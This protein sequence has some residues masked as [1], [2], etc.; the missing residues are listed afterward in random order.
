[1]QLRRFQANSTAMA[2][3]AIRKAFGDDAVILSNRQ[4]NDQV[5]MIATGSIDD[6][7]LTSAVLEEAIDAVRQQEPASRSAPSKEAADKAS[8]TENDN[9]EPTSNEVMGN[10]V[11]SAAAVASI[12][13][14]TSIPVQA[15]VFPEV[16]TATDS[17]VGSST[18]VTSGTTQF[19]LVS[20]D[21]AC[22]DISSAEADDT[23]EVPKVD[24]TVDDDL[25]D[26]LAK[27]V[28]VDTA[29]RSDVAT[30]AY[31][32]SAAITDQRVTT[33]PEASVASISLLKHADVPDASTD[34][35][36]GASAASIARVEQRLQR[37]EAN[38]WG[39]LEP[40]KNTHI[41]QLL[42]IGIGAELAVRLV[43]RL[44]PEDTIDTAIRQS[45]SLLG[46]SLP[47][48]VD[49]STFEPGV[50]FVSGPAGG[51]KTTALLKLAKR[52][53]ELHG[54]DSVVLISADTRD[55][56]AFEAL[57]YQGNRLGVPVV[58]ARESKEL[59]NLIEAFSSKA[60]VLVD[61]MPI[62]H[63]DAF[64][65]PEMAPGETR[66]LRHLLALPASLQPCAVEAQACL[67][68]QAGVTHVVLTQLDA[69]A[70]LGACFAPLIR[71]HLPIA[72]WSDNAD[73][74]MPLERADASVLVATAMATARRFSPSADE[75]CQLNLMRPT[76]QS[77]PEELLVS[78]ETHLDA[79]GAVELI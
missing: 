49:S 18:E 69:T 74:S 52:Q 71:Q 22:D 67:H 30:V 40:V 75:C 54:N 10:E 38:L 6:E 34:T 3:E 46:S 76:R 37:L 17:R 15:A 42:K 20:A 66:K 62:D 59:A 44:K 61:H 57:Q 35:T 1:M 13:Y 19:D 26:Q 53:C 47:V 43:E 12:K 73:T 14:S 16:A 51:G 50:T 68:K 48:G 29:S 2:M 79:T 21:G 11:D 8:E 25:A 58:Q 7:S 24:V 60:L 72:Y 39:E 63:E 23:T 33:S 31:R 77:V 55:N 41:E 5:E 64:S 78:G 27:M 56:G 9:G 32:D 36:V 4:V 65:L 28:A 45:L 70:R